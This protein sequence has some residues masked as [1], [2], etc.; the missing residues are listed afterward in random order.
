MTANLSTCIKC[1]LLCGPPPLTLWWAE[2]WQRHLFLNTHRS[3]SDS[4]MKH[5]PAHHKFR[6]LTLIHLVAS[7]AVTAVTSASPGG[8]K[9]LRGFRGPIDNRP[10][11][12]C[13]RCSNAPTKDSWAE[14][15]FRI[16]RLRV[17]DKNTEAS[18]I[19]TKQD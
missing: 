6:A 13:S 15:E 2:G 1:S 8:T 11:S 4:H 3:I 7:R 18:S 12:A 16:Y 19:A 9:P 17:P 14:I 10:H 5:L